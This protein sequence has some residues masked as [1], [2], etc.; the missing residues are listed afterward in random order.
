[1]PEKMV[2]IG[3]LGRPHGVKGEVRMT[4][5]ADS[6][7]LIHGQVWLQSGKLPPQPITVSTMRMHQGSPLV[8]FEGISDRSQAETLRGQ[9]VLVPESALPECEENEIYL[10]SLIGFD[11]FLDSTGK[12]LGVLDHVLFYGNQET[13]G[14]VTED[15]KEVYL[16]AIPDF[17]RS[18]D[19]EKR[20]IVVAPPEGLLEIYLGTESS[21]F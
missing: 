17:V 10:Y 6:P 9:T 2:E 11:I 12:K 14:I 3:V 4:L 21:L 18:I 20:H 13:W 8:L 7:D 19:Q 1:M 5:Y 16:P 15:G